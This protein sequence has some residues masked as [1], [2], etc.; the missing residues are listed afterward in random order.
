MRTPFPLPEPVVREI[1][2]RAYR[3][4]AFTDPRSVD[5]QVVASFTRHL[6][7]RRDVVRALAT[8]RR[9]LPEL[10]EV[11]DARIEVIERCGHCPQIEAPERLARLLAEFPAPLARAA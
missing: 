10:R 8:G 2:G 11:V 4:L 1:V 5:P 9:L 3:E 6:S 7:S